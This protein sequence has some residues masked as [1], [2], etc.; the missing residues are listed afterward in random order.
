MKKSNI[1]VLLAFAVCALAIPLTSGCSAELGYTLKTDE[2]GN[3]YYSVNASGFTSSLEGELV[4]P[5]SY[6][7]GSER[8]PVREIAP[9]G[10]AGTSIR[11]VV[12][13]STVTKIGTAA[14]AYNPLLT[15]VEFAEGIG[16]EEISWGS[17][18]YCDSLKEIT[19]PESVTTIDGWAFYGCERLE[20]IDLPAGLKY[21]N[22][23]A[24]QNCSALDGVALPE[25]LEGIGS[26]AFYYCTALQSIVLPDSLED[27]KLEEPDEEGNLVTYTQTAVGTGAF[28]S[29]TSLKLAVVGGGITTLDAGVFGY[30]TALEELYL[31]AGLEKICGAL[32]DNG[33][34]LVCA[35]ALHSA[36]SLTKI[37][38]GGTEEEW[39]AVEIENEPFTAQGVTLDNSAVFNAQKTFNTKYS[40]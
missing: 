8:Y 4:I 24:F 30:C 20:K 9:E 22:T 26:Y 2:Q 38:F 16:L 40:A 28:H 5:E 6:G 11:K 3:K 15:K 23:R 12:I 27:C 34:D 1:A 21:I 13:P 17:F 36:Q 25:G 18:G 39:G 31:P 19:I 37:Y 29:C 35:H 7:E 14:F 32:Y 10:F 33:G